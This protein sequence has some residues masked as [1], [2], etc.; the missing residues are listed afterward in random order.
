MRTLAVDAEGNM[1]Y[2]TVPI[3]Q[4]GTKGCT[5]IGHISEGQNKADFIK[6]CELIIV[7][8]GLLS[9]QMRFS[10]PVRELDDSDKFYQAKK[11]FN[12]ELNEFNDELDKLDIDW[13]LDKDNRAN[14]ELELISEYHVDDVKTIE[15]AIGFITMF[16]ASI[17]GDYMPKRHSFK[18]YEAE[19]GPAGALVPE[20]KNYPGLV[21]AISGYSR[22]SFANTTR[23]AYPKSL[24]D[25]ESIPKDST[26]H[27][28]I[29]DAIYDQ[30]YIVK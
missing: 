27:F 23:V 22:N 14:L 9:E 17:T 18:D 12:D 15:K 1:S 25:A 8:R 20:F 29:S 19:Y 6:D 5:H 28:E 26:A 3:E 16:R 7:G 11:D 10:D 30:R 13:I 2:C 4:R 21:R 24:R